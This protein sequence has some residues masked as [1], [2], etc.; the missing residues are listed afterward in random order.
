MD[1]KWTN[2]HDKDDG[3]QDMDGM[4]RSNRWKDYGCMQENVWIMC[5]GHGKCIWMDER[6]SGSQDQRWTKMMNNRWKRIGYVWKG[7]M[8]GACPQCRVQ[9]EEEK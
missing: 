7:S 3:M 6:K 1:E 5:K 9:V 8:D 2:E 4:S